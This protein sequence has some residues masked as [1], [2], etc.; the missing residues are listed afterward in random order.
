M[1]RVRNERNDCWRRQSVIN[2]FTLLL[3]LHGKM[4]I[5]ASHS[6][7]DTVCVTF[8]SHKYVIATRTVRTAKWNGETGRRNVGAYRIA[9]VFI[10]AWNVSNIDRLVIGSKQCDCCREESITTVGRSADNHKCIS[11]GADAQLMH[12][13]PSNVHRINATRIINTPSAMRRRENSN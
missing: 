10:L 9:I 3:L 4:P 5:C 6:V 8:S 1:Q 13:Q 11:C 2:W 12:Q 7:S